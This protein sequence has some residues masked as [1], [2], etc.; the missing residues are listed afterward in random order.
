MQQ[1]QINHLIFAVV[2]TIVISIAILASFH[3]MF[4]DS[5]AFSTFDAGI[6][7]FVLFDAISLASYLLYKRYL[8]RKRTIS[9]SQDGT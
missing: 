7:M 3:I 1:P 8:A 6:I 9:D 4:L 2:V 5:W